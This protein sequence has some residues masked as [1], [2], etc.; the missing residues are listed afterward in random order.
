MDLDSFKWAF[1]LLATTFLGGFYFLSKRISGVHGR[2]DDVRKDYVRRDDF[3]DHM[4]R[5]EK[6]ADRIEKNMQ[7]L[8]DKM[9]ELLQRK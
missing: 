4:D 9:S 8:N 2:I 6:S 7:N 3:K 1:G 5:Q